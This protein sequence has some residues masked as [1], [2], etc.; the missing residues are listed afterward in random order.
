MAIDIVRVIAMSTLIDDPRAGEFGI[1]ELVEN[2]Y[3]DDMADLFINMDQL[4]EGESIETVDEVTVTEMTTVPIGTW[5]ND[6][7]LYTEHEI[8]AFKLKD[9]DGWWT[10]SDMIAVD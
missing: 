3:A 5:F 6:G 8:F 1:T 7:R 4:D 2:G 9:R 10:F